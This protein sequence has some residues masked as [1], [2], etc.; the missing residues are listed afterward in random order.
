MTDL[1]KLIEA[2][3]AGEASLATIEN[4]A[5]LAL[6]LGDSAINAGQAYRGSLDAAKA[7]HDALLPDF[8]W[9]RGGFVMTVTD[10]NT[11]WGNG[12]YARA[13]D[14]ES[15]ARAWLLAVLNAHRAQ[16]QE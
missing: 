3:E 2:V 10:D 6:G 12:I 1:D 4:M 11:G 7:L 5:V 8:F 13:Y 16:V 9:Q 15:P 14:R